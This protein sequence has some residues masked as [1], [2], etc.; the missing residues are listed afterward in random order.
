[1]NDET[2][3]KTIEDEI[4]REAIVNGAT[5]AWNRTSGFTPAATVAQGVAA[6]CGVD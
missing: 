2:K 5:E 4:T 6:A 1:M 3:K